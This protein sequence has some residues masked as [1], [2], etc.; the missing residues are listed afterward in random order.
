MIRDGMRAE[1]ALYGFL[2]LL[3]MATLR[4]TISPQ[5]QSLPQRMAQRAK[6][7]REDSAKLMIANTEQSIRDVGADASHELVN[8]VEE[9][10]PREDRVRVGSKKPQADYVEN[11]RKPGKVPP[12]REFKAILEKW[13]A[14]KGLHFDNLYAVVQKL[15]KVGFYGQSAE[16]KKPFQKARDKSEPMIIALWQKAFRGL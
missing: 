9:F 5:L 4:I 8:S 3:I 7:A 2:F 15:R 12:W 13:A 1:D 14:A 16:G 10:D 11:G 6:A